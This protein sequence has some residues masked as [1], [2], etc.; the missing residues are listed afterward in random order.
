M[1]YIVDT[2]CPGLIY[3]ADIHTG[4]HLPKVLSG[5]C[6]K[7]PRTSVLCGS[8]NLTPE[9]PNAAYS[10]G[11]HGPVT[12]WFGSALPGNVIPVPKTFALLGVGVFCQSQWNCFC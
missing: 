2:L 9:H 12:A 3:L 10:C 8:D 5:H 11:Q 1:K 7:D 4:V 6:D